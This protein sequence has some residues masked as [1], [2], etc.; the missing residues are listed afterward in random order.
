MYNYN[1]VMKANKQ[2]KTET[3]TGQFTLVLVFKMK[4]IHYGTSIIECI[5]FHLLSKPFI[6]SFATAIFFSTKC[7]YGK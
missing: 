5:L 4:Y 2:N 6:L 3:M 1:L 7:R